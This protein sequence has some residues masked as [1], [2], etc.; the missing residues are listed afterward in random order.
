MLILAITIMPSILILA[1]VILSDKFREPLKPILVTFFVGVFLC[2]PAGLLNSILIWSQD[3]PEHYSF[4][5]GVTEESLKFIA[6]IFFVRNMAEF[7]EPMDAIVYGTLISLGFATLENFEYVFN[8]QSA[9]ESMQ[10]AILRA[11][12]AIPLHAACGVIMGYFFGLYAFSGRRK[13]LI[14]SL[15]LPMIFHA[16]YNFMTTLSLLITAL[17]LIALITYAR[18]LH[19]RLARLQTGKTKEEERENSLQ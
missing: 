16:I 19:R 3:S 17:I 14:K 4:L 7:D 11:V 6:I 15:F 13:Y 2:F 8:S 18:S 12:T 1:A 10:I 5:A 9:A